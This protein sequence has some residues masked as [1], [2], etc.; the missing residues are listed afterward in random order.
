[1]MG[2]KKI[3]FSGINGIG[4]SAIAK[5][6]KLEGYDVKGSD[7]SYTAMTKSL[8]EIGI[9][10]YTKQLSE[11]V[12]KF[13][14]DI[15]VYT[16]A[17]KENNEEYMYACQK[18][19]VKKRRGTMLADI[20]NKYKCKIAIAGTHGKTTTSSMLSITL[21]DK[22]PSI[23]VGGI[24]PVIQSN[25]RIGKS[26]IFVTEAD[27]SDNS[28]LELY[29]NISVV[30]NIESDHLENH[31]SLENIKKSFLKFLSQ[32][33]QKILLSAD[34]K[35]IQS[36]NLD[37]FNDRIVWY[38]IEKKA[39]IYARNIR[40][41]DSITKYE[42]VLENK[43]LGEF[44]LKVPGKHNVS[45]SLAVIY[46]SMML[47]VKLEDIKL[48]LLNFSG[49]KRRYQV[50]Y[51][52]KFKLIDDYA[53]HPTEIKATLNAARSIEKGEIIAIFEPHRYTRTA[54]FKNDFAKSLSNADKILLLPIYSASENNTQ[55]ISSNDIKL[56]IEKI[57]NKKRVELVTKDMLFEKI[58]KNAKK[59]DVF[60]FMGA[61]SISKLAYEIAEKLKGIK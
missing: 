37:E 11:N 45:N 26:G 24:V 55:N 17:I 57:D 19:I 47:G 4:M 15:F 9:T 58:S 30:T 56:E 61:G 50:I 22:D 20:F 7:I 46:I 28:F 35:N 25:T 29:P 27:E 48:A 2:S 1:M 53:H 13:N 32:T 60:I 38:S 8:E 52:N 18:N 43:S 42:V 54:F 39:N 59:G 23:M 40:V 41:E 21:L 14:P 12:E 31:G 6:L 51:D 34:C 5:M 16:S 10:V 33:D 44:L 3:Y 36:L 49:A